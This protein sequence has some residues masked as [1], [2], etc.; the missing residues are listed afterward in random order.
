[1][2]EKAHIIDL[3][4][5]WE[6]EI[7]ENKI[8]CRAVGVATFLILMSLGAF[9]RIYLP[10]SPVPITAQTFF[11]LL[12]GAILGRRLGSFT[13]VFYAV[14]G[15]LGLPVFA[16]ASFGFAYILGPTGGY[17]IG[18]VF[19][20]CITGWLI[21][22]RKESGFGWVLFSMAIGSLLIYLFGTIQLMAIS[23]AGLPFI[24]YI[25]ILPF[26]PGDIVKIIVAALLYKALGKR[27]KEIFKIL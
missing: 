21:S 4:L 14:L 13:Q 9:L 2:A 18:F 19:A 3:K 22:I 27:S 24:I 7:I 10:F 1:M 26:I 6:K 20:A 17:I 8:V 23:K 5:A 25:G 12:S 15:G 16:S 11:V